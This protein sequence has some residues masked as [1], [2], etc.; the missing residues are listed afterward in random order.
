MGWNGY[1]ALQCSEELDEAKVKANVEA[2]VDSG[3]QSAGYQYV[4]LDVCWELA[5]AAGGERVFDPERLPG[6][7]AGLSQYVHERGFSLGVWAPSEDCRAT[8]GGRGHET[9]DAESYA[10]WGIDYLKYVQCGTPDPKG[11][12]SAMAG[13]LERTGRAIVLSVSAAPFQEWMSEVGELWRTSFDAEPTWASLVR[14]IDATVPL[15]AYARPGAFSDPDMLE[16]GNAGLTLS[17]QRVQFSVW[18]ILSAPLLAGNDLSTM[19]E[20]TRAL[21][22]NQRLIAVDQDPLGLQAALIRREGDVDILAKPLAECGSR[23]VVFWNRGEGTRNV[24]VTWQELWLEGAS[25]SAEDLWN[26]S[27]VL[28]DSQ[29]LVVTVPPHDAV[30]LRVIGLE[31]PLPL[32]RPYLSDLRWTY[33]TN[34]FGPVEVDATNGEDGALDGAPIRLRGAA[35]NRG[36]GVHGPSLVRYRLGQRCSRFLADVG[37]DDDQD[38]RGS[39]EFEVWADGKRLFSSGLLTGTSPIVAANVDVSG[40]RDLRLFVNTGGDTYSLDHAVWAGARLECEATE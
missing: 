25:A 31:P 1:N 16:I 12:F 17:E 15:A 20:E 40:R 36:L 37:I 30:A 35:Y 18:S 21:L 33:A 19:N 39:A 8:P 6:G 4:N 34:G 5:R 27:P 13:A 32:G 2:L 10:A 23:A 28:S 29:G 14:Q 7:I 9:V 3:M 22:T 26:A 24:P 11:A 38:G